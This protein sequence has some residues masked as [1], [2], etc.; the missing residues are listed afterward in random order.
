[1]KSFLRMKSFLGSNIWLVL[2]IASLVVRASEAF[3]FDDLTT[4]QPTVGSV[5]TDKHYIT[6]V[7]MIQQEKG[8]RE[9]Y[10]LQIKQDY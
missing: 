7:D 1:M 9:Q 10:M 8:L 5:L 6:L 2:F 3:L 4:K